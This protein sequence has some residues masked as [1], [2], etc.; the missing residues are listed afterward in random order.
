LDIDV[1][2]LL[3]YGDLVAVA[4]DLRIPLA[5]IQKTVHSTYKL[6]WPGGKHLTVR[7]RCEFIK[8]QLMDGYDHE[9]GEDNK[10]NGSLNET[11]APLVT[12]KVQIE[13]LVVTGGVVDL[14]N[15]VDVY[16]TLAGA[17]KILADCVGEGMT[18][19]KIA[20]RLGRRFSSVRASISTLLREKFNLTHPSSLEERCQYLCEA[21]GLAIQQGY[22]AVLPSKPVKGRVKP[23]TEIVVENMK[24]VTDVPEVRVEEV[25]EKS[26]YDEPVVPVLTENVPIAVEAAHNLLTEP[27]FLDG[28]S[29]VLDVAVILAHPLPLEKKIEEFA[30]QGFL[31]EKLC[32]Y[33][34]PAKQTLCAD[35][36]FVKRRKT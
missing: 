24:Q 9:P 18:L 14:Q 16:R 20:D 27:L 2:R 35:A 23:E 21:Y 11:A 29:S 19:E 34:D 6:F 5:E 12:T 31:A 17:P 28:P 7:E 22:S 36:I 8:S 13:E 3:P 1:L 15:L 25:P 30:A 10:V 32:I 26:D 4:E 33:I